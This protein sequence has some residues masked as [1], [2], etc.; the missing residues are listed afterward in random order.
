MILK[1]VIWKLWQN[2]VFDKVF[3]GF[4]SCLSVD[5][6]SGWYDG[7]LQVESKLQLPIW[8]VAGNCLQNEYKKK[9]PNSTC[10]EVF[11]AAFLNFGSNL[12]SSQ[13]DDDDRHENLARFG[14][15]LNM[16][17]I[18]NTCVLLNFWLTT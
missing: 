4:L 1:I 5:Y 16:K 12:C 14:Y 8:F 7:R 9:L 13:H 11:S 18:K 3:G 2:C 10:Q 6:Q 17:V 15:K